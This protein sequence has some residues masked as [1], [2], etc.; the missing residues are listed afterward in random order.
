MNNLID[1]KSS[2]V[3][4]RMKTNLK[5]KAEKM[6]KKMGLNPSQVVNALYV[7]IVLTRSIPFK[8]KIPNNETL[9]AIQELEHEGKDSYR[10]VDEMFCDI[11]GQ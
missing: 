7:Q 2:T 3:Q 1:K 11:L 6:I 9:K 5:N 10:T 4:V 8:I